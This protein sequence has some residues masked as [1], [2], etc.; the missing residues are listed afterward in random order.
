RA[1]IRNSGFDFPSRRITVNLAPAD[2]RKDGSSLDLPMAMGI[3]AASRQIDERL[4]EGYVFVG[5]LSLEGKLRR[6]NGMLAMADG[7]SQWAASQQ[8]PISLLVP[9]T[10]QDEAALVRGLTI[11]AAD[12]LA[13]IVYHLLG[14]QLL[15]P[16]HEREFSG[17]SENGGEDFA[18]VSGQQAAKRALEIAVAGGHNLLM[19][20]PPGAG[21]TMLARRL[22]SIMPVL[23]AEEG[24][25][26]ARIYSIAGLTDEGRLFCRRPFRA[27]HHTLSAAS[28]AGGGRVPRPG[29]VTLSHN[30]VLFMDEFPEFPREVLEVLRQPL[31]DGVITVS[32]VSATMIY[33]ARFMLVAAMNPC[34]CGYLTDKRRQCTCSD[35]EIRRYR[36]RVSGPLLDR[37][38][39]VI[40]L[41]RVEYD[42]LTA[43]I[44][45]GE[46]S[47][48]I[49]QRVE[50]AREL[51]AVRLK[52]SRHRCNGQMGHAMIRRTCVMNPAAE[53]LLAGLF[54]K[55]KLSARGYDR[56]VKVART[57]A[58]IAGSDEIE[59]GH[60]AEAAALRNDGLMI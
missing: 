24:M 33:P 16:V 38:D 2:M 14:K 48:V 19:I 52:R 1:A 4:V 6:I 55:L 58:D 47:N 59:A 44:P 13:A 10:N 51:Q 43:K 56:L 41:P 5:E 60:V 23:T 21:K 57:I 35:S 11:W 30:G 54:E 37:I 8:R 34:P 12:D 26:I 28:M 3:V 15:T 29:E 50:K 53:K 45:A 9:A 25:E 31:E 46:S 36:R 7:V 27:P 42:E 40:S 39:I 17:V 20:G 18:E 32:R 22:P 49:R